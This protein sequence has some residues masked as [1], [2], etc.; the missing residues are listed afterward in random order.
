[1]RIAICAVSALALSGCS[2][3][4][5]GQSGHSYKSQ[6]YGY[7]KT[8]HMSAQG[9]QRQSHCVVYS[10]V[11]PI[12]NGCHPSQVTLA[13]GAGGYGSQSGHGSYATGGYGSHAGQ[14]TQH[15]AN[16]HTEA[17][18]RKPKLRGSFSMGFEKSNAGAF[19]NYADFPGVDPEFGY[20]PN[21]FLETYVSGTPAGGEVITEQYSGVVENVVK[22]EISFDD[23]HSTPFRIAGGAEYIVSPKATLF[24]N[25]GYSYS[26][27]EAGDAVLVQ[28]A[29][30]NVTTTQPYHEVTT[31]TIIGT[32][33][34]TGEPITQDTTSIQTNGP[35]VTTSNSYPNAGALAKFAYDFNDMQRYDFEV[36]GR[37][38][39]DPV[40]KDQGVNTLTPFVS[41]SAGLSHHNAQSFTI[42]QEQAFYRE[43][44]ENIQSGATEGI[45]EYYDPALGTQ[46]VDLYDSQWIPSGAVMAGLEWQ[47]TPKTALAFETGVRFEG[48]RE[49][50]NGES[51]DSNIA[52]PMTLRG[53]FNF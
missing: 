37:Y 29:L 36:G 38:Y 51:G 7:N 6:G 2:W 24:A 47:L 12:P 16:Y 45:T 34:V 53:S 3:L 40:I 52:I 31:T 20:N 8:A 14:A 30:T 21:D 9:Q 26:E 25:V 18:L 10:P 44:Y 15:G 46:T 49:Y 17:K 27:G 35:S 32:N 33:P 50:T 39:F 23:V 5:G 13:T 22:P 41:A 43:N 42:S 28:G 4:G 11:Q 1:M 19:L 48:A